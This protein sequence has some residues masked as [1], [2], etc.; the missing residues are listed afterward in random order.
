MP[1]QPGNSGHP[2][3]QRRAKLFTEAL[4]MEIAAAG[5]DNKAL[6]RVARALLA[7]AYKGNIAAIAMIADR[8]DGKVPQPVGGNDDLGPRRL[9][10]TWGGQTCEAADQRAVV[11][12]TPSAAG[13]LPVPSRE[14]D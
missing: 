14:R 9:H 13:D 12:T 7:E 4:R 1:F 11:A 10:I 6:R 5:D 8:L 2:E 3:G